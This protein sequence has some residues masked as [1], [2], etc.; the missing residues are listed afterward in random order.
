MASAYA[1]VNRSLPARALRSIISRSPGSKK[2]TRPRFRARTFSW[3]IS[4]TQT[5]LPR[6][7]RHAAVVRPTYP[8]PT[9]AIRLT[10]GALSQDPFVDR[11]GRF[12]GGA[13][14]KPTRPGQAGRAQPRRQAR[15]QRD[16]GRRPAHRVR[17]PVV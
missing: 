15:V 16:L 14:R 17:V 4:T 7:A 2:C 8:A 12:G 3:S 11:D 9:T 6:S 5:S 13:P 10:D 1:E